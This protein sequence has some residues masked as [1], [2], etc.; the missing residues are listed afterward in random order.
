MKKLLALFIVGAVAWVAYGRF[1]KPPEKRACQRLADLCGDDGD[2]GKCVK[3]IAEIGKMSREAV[4]KL[5]GCVAGA[6][7]CGEAT[8]CLFGAG[9]GAV[10]TMFTDF[11]KGVG[12]SLP[13]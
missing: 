13:R 12:K 2:A 3:D 5:D 11:M 10:G 7:S 1:I 6:S 8:G 4:T 9:A